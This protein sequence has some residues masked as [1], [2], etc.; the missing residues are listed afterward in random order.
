MRA[1]WEDPGGSWGTRET[2]LTCSPLSSLPR[3]F[4]AAAHLLCLPSLLAQRLRGDAT[5]WRQNVLSG[6]AWTGATW[7]LDAGRAREGRGG[8]WWLCWFSP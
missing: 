6:G 3:H 4:Y 7:E 2:S 1:S 5:I 8:G